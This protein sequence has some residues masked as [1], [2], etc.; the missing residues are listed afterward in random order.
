[1]Q[2]LI[3]KGAGG[4]GDGSAQRGHSGVGQIPWPR[5]LHAGRGAH[6]GLQRRHE[7]SELLRHMAQGLGHVDIFHS[8]TEFLHHRAVGEVHS[9]CEPGI[10]AVESQGE[11]VQAQGKRAPAVPFNVA[12]GAEGHAVEVE[13]FEHRTGHVAVH[14]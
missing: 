2:S 1:M 14:F 7:W 5:Q 9:R 3:F 10:E 11:V 4:N 8:G 6:I 13:L 12:V